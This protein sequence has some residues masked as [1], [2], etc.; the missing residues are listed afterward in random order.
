MHRPLPSNDDVRWAMDQVLADAR[1]AG[2][3]PTV[4]AVERALEIRHAT[5]YRNYRGLVTDYFQPQV[6]ADTPGDARPAHAGKLVQVCEEAI[7]QLTLTHLDLC[8]KVNTAAEVTA[9]P[10]RR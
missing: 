8:E 6:A 10:T 3:H 7:R 5:F 4:F 1:A 9:L 2:R